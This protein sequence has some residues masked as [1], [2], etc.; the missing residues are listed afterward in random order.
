MICTSFGPRSWRSKRRPAS[1]RCDRADLLADAAGE[2]DEGEQQQQ[3]AD[4]ERRELGREVVGRRGSSS[5]SVLEAGDLAR[6]RYGSRAKKAPPITT[7]ARLR[8]PPT[9]V[10]ITKTSARLKFH[11]SGDDERVVVGEQRAG[12]AGEDA[13]DDE[14]EQRRAAAR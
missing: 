2:L 7:P 1:Q 3:R 12:E 6:C 13:G 9:T 5:S 11:I 4:H 14:G 10:M 8:R